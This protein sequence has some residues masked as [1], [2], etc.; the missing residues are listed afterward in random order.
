LNDAQVIRNADA[1]DVD[2]VPI[3]RYIQP[4]ALWWAFDQDSAAQRGIADPGVG[5]RTNGVV[6]LIDEIDKADPDVPNNLLES[7]G[8][9]Q[10]TVAETGFEVRANPD[11]V[12]LVIITTNDERELPAAFYRRCVVHV[13]PEHKTPRLVE[14]AEQHFPGPKAI[15]DATAKTL[16]ESIAAE[17]ERYRTEADKRRE[18]RPSTAEYLDAVR[19]C[20]E[21][22]IDTNHPDWGD[23][24]N[25]TLTKRASEPSV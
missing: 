17:V 5:P 9:L 13:L 19:A 15:D 16:F 18:R 12:P 7:L 11:Q 8:S 21:L 25:L 4:R 1:A 14:I 10:F 2:P 20:L 22:G 6:V 3:D 24:A 23:V